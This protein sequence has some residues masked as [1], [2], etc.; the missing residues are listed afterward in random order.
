MAT[1][2][3]RRT[4]EKVSRHVYFTRRLPARFN[5]LRLRIS[6]SASLK[7]WKGFEQ[8][9]FN[10]IYDFVENYVKPGFVVWDVGANV[11]LFAFS[12]ASRAQREGRVLCLEP[13]HWSVSLLKR[14]CAYNRGLAAPVD[15]LPMAVSDALSIEWLN[16]PNR[17]RA[18]T[19]LDLAGGAGQDLVGGVR[20]Q[21]LVPTVTLDWVA[22]YYPKPQI[23]KIDTDGAELR[24]LNGAL[25]LLR[26]C[27]PIIEI[28]VYERNADAVTEFLI[29]LGYVLYDY[30]DGESGKRRVER[31]V[32]NT[33]AIP[34]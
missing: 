33:L 34:S 20:E 4:L 18:A 17:S 29:K 7:Y 27:R 6:P 19:H 31:A 16:V 13:D 26:E 24:V 32:Y 25:S 10:D 23:I 21:H 5:R 30:N 28:E 15:I 14:S 2:V 11:G 8:P 1:S 3:L 9:G 12:A 22:N